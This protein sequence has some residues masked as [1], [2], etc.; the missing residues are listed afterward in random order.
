MNRGPL[1]KGNESTS[2]IRT[3]FL[4]SCKFVAYNLCLEIRIPGYFVLNVGVRGVPL[5]NIY[6]SGGD[7]THR[8]VSGDPGPI[9]GTREGQP[10]HQDCRTIGL[11]DACWIMVQ[12]S[13]GASFTV[14]G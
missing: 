10:L 4:E 1:S 8:R 9:H 3:P 2:Q 7:C 12:V 11:V 14:G 5:C 6:D 13:E